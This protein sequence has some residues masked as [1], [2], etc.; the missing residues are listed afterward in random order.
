[1]LLLSAA[2]T[3]Q[4]TT[5]GIQY[6]AIPKFRSPTFGGYFIGLRYYPMSAVSCASHCQALPLPS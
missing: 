3:I 4:S 5:T 1:M 2:Q 6:D